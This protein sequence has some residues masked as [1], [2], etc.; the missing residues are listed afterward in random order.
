MGLAKVHCGATPPSVMVLLT[1]VLTYE[2]WIIP[3][4]LSS[5]IELHRNITENNTLIVVLQYAS[6]YH[7]TVQQHNFQYNTQVQNDVCS[8]VYY[9]KYSTATQFTVRESSTVGRV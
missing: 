5:S 2:E 6:L 4:D 1:P 9:R 3:A 8:L 7:H